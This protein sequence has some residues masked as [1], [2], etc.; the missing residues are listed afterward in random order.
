MDGSELGV[1]VQ[2]GAIEAREGARVLS[3]V[4]DLASYARRSS[5]RNAFRV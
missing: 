3:D 4:F 2:M 1:V 5:L